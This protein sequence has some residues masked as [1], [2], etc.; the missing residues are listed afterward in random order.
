M[1]DR[2]VGDWRNGV[3]LDEEMTAWRTTTRRAQWVFGVGFAVSA[4][5]L[6]V[7]ALGGSSG[8]VYF[9]ASSMLVMAVFVSAM[10]FLKRKLT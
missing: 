4:V 6:L 10:T 2:R 1:P 7:S 3:D 9:T 8:G 5:F